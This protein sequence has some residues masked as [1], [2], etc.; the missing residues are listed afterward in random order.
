MQ[1]RQGAKK[2]DPELQHRRTIAMAEPANTL[3]EKKSYQKPEL[4]SIALAA[5]EVLASGCKSPSI[6]IAGL[7]LINCVVAPCA[8]V[9]S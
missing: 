5:E 7:S 2:G 8:A 6:F 1:F 4:T 3:K 9:G